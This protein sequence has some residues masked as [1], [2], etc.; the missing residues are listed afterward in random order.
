MFDQ[1]EFLIELYKDSCRYYYKFSL[2]NNH[3]MMSYELGRQ[4][5]I[6][7]IGYIWFPEI[8]FAKIDK[9]VYAS[10]DNEEKE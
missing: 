4:R 9:E 5:V 10:M 6:R 3:D 7:S 8:D 2:E 1:K